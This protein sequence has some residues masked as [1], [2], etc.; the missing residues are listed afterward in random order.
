MGALAAQ[1]LAQAAL[2]RMEPLMDKPLGVEVRE[3][4][5]IHTA[6][7]REALALLAGRLEQPSAGQV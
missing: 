6:T 4:M 2:V 7:V 3:P 5:E 1:V